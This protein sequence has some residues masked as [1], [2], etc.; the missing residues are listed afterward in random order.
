MN[1]ENV[2]NIVKGYVCCQSF[3]VN[4]GRME[5]HNVNRILRKI[6]MSTW[7]Y[8][9]LYCQ[10]GTVDLPIITTPLPPFLRGIL[11]FGFNI[12]DNRDDCPT[13]F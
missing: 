1:D 13:M 12:Y 4:R 3:I 11:E 10:P 6:G 8:G 2:N 9:K 7:V 5:N